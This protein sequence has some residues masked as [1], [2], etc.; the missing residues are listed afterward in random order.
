MPFLFVD[1]NRSC[2]L[3]VK[4]K[5]SSNPFHSCNFL[6]ADFSSSSSYS[7]RSLARSLAF[8]LRLLDKAQGGFYFL[9]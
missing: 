2:R 3:K 1:Q 8:L 4:L 6:S 5:S 9:P 7:S